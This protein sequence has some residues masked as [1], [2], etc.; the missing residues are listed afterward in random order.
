MRQEAENHADDFLVDDEQ[1]FN[2]SLESHEALK[3][4]PGQKKVVVI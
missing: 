4:Y 1:F 3:I 2:F